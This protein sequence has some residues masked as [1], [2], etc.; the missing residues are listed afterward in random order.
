MRKNL[1][2]AI[3]ILLCLNAFFIPFLFAESSDKYIDILSISFSAMGSVATLITLIIALFLFQKF[4]LESKFVERKTDKVLELVDL[5]KGKVITV[6]TEKFNYFLRTN[7]TDLEQF[8]KEKFYDSVFPKIM[9]L[10][11]EDYSKSMDEIVEI[12]KSYWLPTEIKDKLE[13][14]VFPMSV[15]I[16]DSMDSKFGRFHYGYETEEQWSKPHPE[17]TVEEYTIKQNELVDEIEKWLL[18]HSD[19]NIELNLDEKNPKSTTA[20]I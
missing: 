6:K 2:I 18:K 20:N 4:G 1:I 15:K 3:S 8:K 5:L 7:K 13:F 11:W 14:I 10:R 9:L 17:T 16:D 19:I 12:R